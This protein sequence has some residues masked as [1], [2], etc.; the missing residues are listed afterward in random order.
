MENFKD[1]LT[2]LTQYSALFLQD[3]EDHQ[4]DTSAAVIA[5]DPFWKTN[6]FPLLDVVV[7]LIKSCGGCDIMKKGAVKIYFADF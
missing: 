7:S 5:I 4:R 3:S 2:I 6:A 1:H